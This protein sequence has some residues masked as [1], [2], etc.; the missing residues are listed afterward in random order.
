MTYVVKTNNCYST[1][2]VELHYMSLL[3]PN[4][5]INLRFLS[6]VVFAALAPFF[7]FFSTSDRHCAC[8]DSFLFDILSSKINKYY[9]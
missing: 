4:V 6:V 3:S 2:A 5:K 8:S 7:Q 1:V 9:A